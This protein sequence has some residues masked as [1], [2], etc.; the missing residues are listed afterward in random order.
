[1]SYTLFYDAIITSLRITNIAFEFDTVPYIEPL[2]DYH[3]SLST[4][5][6]NQLYLDLFLKRESCQISF[7]RREIET[8]LFFDSAE[9][10]LFCN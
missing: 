9:F 7:D 4:S 8:R 5:Q 6:S 3:L 2:S 10:A 1:M